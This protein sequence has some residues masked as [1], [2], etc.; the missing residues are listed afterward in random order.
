MIYIS[1]YRMNSRHENGT[2]TQMKNFY[3]ATQF[4][5]IGSENSETVI[6]KEGEA[7]E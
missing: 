1:M 7:G 6:D 2:T 5:K 3:I 4:Q